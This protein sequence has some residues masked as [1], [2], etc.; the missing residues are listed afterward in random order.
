MASPDA[1]VM[2]TIVVGLEG[3]ILLSAAY[4]LSRKLGLA[5]G[6]HF[7]RNFSQD[8][9]FGVASSVRG[10]VRVELAEP[11]LLAGGVPGIEGSVLAPLACV[12]IG[13]YLLLR[14]RRRG[15]FVRPF[16]MQPNHRIPFAAPDEGGVAER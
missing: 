3:G 13:A 16:W 15:D 5:T 2:S 12:V 9:L 6:I 14:A 7:A 10:H 8:A 11:T 4:I 1:T